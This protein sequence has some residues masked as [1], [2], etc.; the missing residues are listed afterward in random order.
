MRTHWPSP[1]A[2]MSAT[3]RQSWSHSAILH[4]RPRGRIEDGERRGSSATRRETKRG[5]GADARA[6][7]EDGAG[8]AD[9]G[10]AEELHGDEDGAA[11]EARREVVH[12]DDA[13]GQDG[14]RGVG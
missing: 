11:V 12:G 1:V 5:R 2:V 14:Q 6:E 4:A 8:A 10:G 3:T 13:T 9:G 7:G